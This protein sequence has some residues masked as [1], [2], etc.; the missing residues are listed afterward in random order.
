M[1]IGAVSNPFFA[2]LRTEQI[3]HRRSRI[4]C[5]L[6][7]GVQKC[8]FGKLSPMEI[9]FIIKSAGSIHGKR[10]IPHAS[11]TLYSNRNNDEDKVAFELKE[12]GGVIVRFGRKFHLV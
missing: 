6:S 8:L 7:G 1:P 12:P 9:Q 3:P 2:I 11:K 4:K 10:R 5:F